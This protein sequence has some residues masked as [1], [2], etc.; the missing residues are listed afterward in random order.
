MTL[1]IKTLHGRMKLIIMAFRITT[2]SIMG[3]SIT[4]QSIITLSITIKHARGIL[5]RS[6]N[7]IK[8][9][10]TQHRHYSA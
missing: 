8:P 7:D 6:M 5:T 4:P 9:N 1:A 10:G 3:I 2:L